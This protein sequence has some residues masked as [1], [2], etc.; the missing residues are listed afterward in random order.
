MTTL[1][2]ATGNND[3]D[4]LAKMFDMELKKINSNIKDGFKDVKIVNNS[5]NDNAELAR[6]LKFQNKR[7]AL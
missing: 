1:A 2:A 5:R 4:K 3:S 6:L 7:D